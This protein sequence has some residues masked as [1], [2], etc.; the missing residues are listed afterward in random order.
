MAFVLRE[1]LAQGWGDARCERPRRVGDQEFVEQAHA[2]VPLMPA[3]TLLKVLK[4][5]SI[6]TRSGRPARPVRAGRGRADGG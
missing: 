6:A 2:K 4:V 1:V 3:A 5:M